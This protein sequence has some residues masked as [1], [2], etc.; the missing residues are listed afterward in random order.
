MYYIFIR[1]GFLVWVMMEYTHEASNA[2]GDLVGVFQERCEFRV[3]KRWIYKQLSTSFWYLIDFICRSMMATTHETVNSN[4]SIGFT[5]SEQ[6]SSNNNQLIY[7][8]VE[9]N[10]DTDHNHSLY[11][12]YYAVQFSTKL[13]IPRYYLYQILRISLRWNMKNTLSIIV[14]RCI[15]L[16]GLTMAPSPI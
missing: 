5:W 8:F 10:V 13:Q 2:V 7:Q 14:L 3:T 6:K 15:I 9:P 1:K 12:T 11:E 16:T 4:L